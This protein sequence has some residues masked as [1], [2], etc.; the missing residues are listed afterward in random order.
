M[1]KNEYSILFCRN[2]HRIDLH[3]FRFWKVRNWSKFKRSNCRPIL[4]VK[5]FRWPKDWLVVWWSPKQKNT[6]GWNAATGMKLKN[7]WD[8]LIKIWVTV[9]IPESNIL[10]SFLKSFLKREF[11]LNEIL[12]SKFSSNI[13]PGGCFK[14]LR[15][16]WRGKMGR[17]LHF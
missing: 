7:Y 1:K 14:E 10:K 4:I 9:V 12:Q 5:I 6:W 13:I 15:T 8:I 11:H 17:I 3:C 16:A 2:L